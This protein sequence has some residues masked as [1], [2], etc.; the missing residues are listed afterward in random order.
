[1]AAGSCQG[2]PAVGATT[3]LCA[4]RLFRHCDAIVA[5]P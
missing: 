5:N 1:L 3:C 2:T 4:V